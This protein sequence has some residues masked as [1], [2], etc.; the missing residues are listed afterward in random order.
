MTEEGGQL[1]HQAEKKVVLVEAD[2]G[3]DH[4]ERELSH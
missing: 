3:R 4:A 2:L 1:G